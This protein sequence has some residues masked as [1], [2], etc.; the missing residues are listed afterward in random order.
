MKSSSSNRTRRRALRDP[1]TP[2]AEQ[3]KDAA[4]F[5]PQPQARFFPPASVLHRSPDA[6]AS[7]EKEKVARAT[8]ER[9]EEKVAKAA[10]PVAEKREE[11]IA[12]KTDGPEPEKEKLARKGQGAAAAAGPKTQE[13]IAHLAGR[14]QPLPAAEQEWFGQHMGFDFAGVRIHTDAEA[15]ES[16]RDAGAKAYAYGSHLVF[17]EGRYAPENSEGRKLLAHELTHVMQQSGAPMPQTGSAATQAHPGSGTVHRQV[18]DAAGA[19]TAPSTPSATTSPSSVTPAMTAPAVASPTDPAVFRTR[20]ALALAQMNTPTVTNETLAGTLE[21]V[22]R[23]MAAQAEWIDAS[24]ASSG[25]SEIAVQLSPTG[26]RIVRLR[27]ILDDNPNPPL[28]GRF[29]AIGSDAGSLRIYTRLANDPDSLAT[30][31]YH[32]SLHLMRWLDRHSPSGDLVA[33]TGATLGRRTTLENIDPA[34]HPSHLAMVR[35]SMAE[36]AASVNATRP[37]T[38]RVTEAG[39]D[40]ASEFVMEEYLVRIETEV[41]RLM[42]DSDAVSRRP[43][44]NVRG[45]TAAEAI[46]QSHDVAQYLFEIN[47]VFRGA[48]RDAIAPYDRSLVENLFQYFRDRVAY[49]VRLRYS[50]VIHGPEYP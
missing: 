14:G 43:G 11:K 23:D 2:Q 21:P 29:D 22:L 38:D 5:G 42:R 10:D 40:R 8:E 45:G 24:G 7:E 15:A 12:A 48:D 26:T 27:M 37:E 30:T 25:G 4:F 17:N 6:T 39:I 19:T 16:A 34:R 35:R 50:E 9:K 46:F 18:G 36:L 28:E 41:F 47:P 33:E 13:Y 32:E 31:L 1:G 20:L 44:A 49:F 3:R